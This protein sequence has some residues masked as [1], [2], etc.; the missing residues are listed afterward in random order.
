MDAQVFS[1]R[2]FGFDRFG[3]EVA[4]H[5]NFGGAELLGDV[6]G[7]GDEILVGVEPQDADLFGRELE[8]EIAGPAPAGLDE[9][10]DEPLMRA[11]RRAMNAQRRLERIVAVA[12]SHAKKRTGI[13]SNSATE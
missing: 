10:T 5:T 4:G 12:I 2:D 1:V 9:E 3:A 6:F 7:V 13:Q 11:E 8:R